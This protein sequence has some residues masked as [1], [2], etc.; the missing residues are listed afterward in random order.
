MKRLAIAGGSSPFTVDLIECLAVQGAPPMALVLQGRNAEELGLVRAFGERRLGPLGW[1]VGQCL[2]RREALRGADIVLQQVRFGGGA[3]RA[4]DERLALSQDIPAD[5]TLGPAALRSALRMAGDLRALARDLADQCP[6]AVVLNLTNPLSL[7]TSLLHIAGVRRVAGLCELPWDTACA[8]AALAGVSGGHFTW[9]YA[10]LNHR[11]FVFG[12]EEDG[13]P[14]LPRFL[15]ALGEGSFSGATAAEIAALG[16]I[17]TKYFALLTG[18]AAVQPGR[19]G[20]VDE[21]RR[22]IVAELRTHPRSLPAGIAERGGRWYRL[23][24]APAI[25]ALCS[26]EERELVLSVPGADAISRELRCAV[27]GRGIAPLAQPPP[28][29]GIVPLLAKFEAHERAMIAAVLDPSPAN[30][31]R[32]LAE[33]PL[34]PAGKVEPL[35][36]ALLAGVVETVPA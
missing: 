16:A 22:R 25:A 19:A 29:A 4:A 9:N 12:L 34:V 15:A 18:R 28:P 30:V 3:G 13:E 7:A 24:V 17:P 1:R 6:D 23:A 36:E 11:G 33:D 20:A 2:D 27:S 21:I 8:A 26:E 5:E 32:A 10:G 14:L 31:R 35:A